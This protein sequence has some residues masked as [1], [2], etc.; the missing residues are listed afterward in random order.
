MA[1]FIALIITAGFGQ[2]DA[3]QLP[4]YIGAMPCDANIPSPTLPQEKSLLA[5]IAP[6]V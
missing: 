6:L 4:P 2:L 5:I 3:R 1:F